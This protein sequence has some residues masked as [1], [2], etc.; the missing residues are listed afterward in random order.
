MLIDEPDCLSVQVS[1]LRM[2]YQQPNIQYMKFSVS[3]E[4]AVHELQLEPG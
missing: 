3:D 2:S 1:G 4:V